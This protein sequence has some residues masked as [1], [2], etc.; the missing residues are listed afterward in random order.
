MA[1]GILETLTKQIEARKTLLSDA[2]TAGKCVDFAEYK[3]VV[4]QV[5]G[6]AASQM[7]IDDLLRNLK[8]KDED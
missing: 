4:G 2:L 5:R 3:Y 8:E 6:L 7:L 1:D